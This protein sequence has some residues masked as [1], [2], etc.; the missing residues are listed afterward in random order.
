ADE[1]VLD[2]L[3]DRV[4][5]VEEAQD[6]EGAADLHDDRQRLGGH[7]RFLMKWRTFPSRMKAAIVQWP[8]DCASIPAVALPLVPTSFSYSAAP[9]SPSS[10]P[11]SW[12]DW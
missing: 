8:V 9:L 11:S 5:L 3:V 1:Q 10:S 4:V 12:R 2:E 6:G 7:D